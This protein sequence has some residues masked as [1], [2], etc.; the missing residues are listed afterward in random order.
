MKGRSTATN[1]L[2]YQDFIIN[3]FEDGRQVDF[4]Y[5]D[6][7]KAF[8]QVSQDLLISKL[9]ESTVLSNPVFSMLST[10]ILYLNRL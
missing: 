7:S 6:L 5:G 10:T 3:S 2:V 8:D 1:V 4:F 9:T